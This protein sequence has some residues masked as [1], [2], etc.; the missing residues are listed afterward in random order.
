MLLSSAAGMSPLESLAGAWRIEEAPRLHGRDHPLGFPNTHWLIIGDRGIV[1]RDAP[2][3]PI[4]FDFRIRID[5]TA[6]PREIRLGGREGGIG[7][8]ETDG[9]FLFICLGPGGAR[10]PRFASDCG[11]YFSFVRDPDFPLP[12]SR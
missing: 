1:I 9:E 7:Y 12:D 8:F 10:P 5:D 2:H 3:E 4:D 11:Q 6:T